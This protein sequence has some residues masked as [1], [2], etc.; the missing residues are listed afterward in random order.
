M[1]KRPAFRA[2]LAR[3]G[4]GTLRDR[5]VPSGCRAKTGTL[6]DAKA[7]ALAGLCRGRVFAI[8]TTGPSAERARR[9]HDQIARVLG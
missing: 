9:V 7:T 2:S 5:A 4:S 3:G 8:L 6:R 1:D